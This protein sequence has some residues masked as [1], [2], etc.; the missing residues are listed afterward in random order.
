[1]T[2]YEKFYTMTTHIRVLDSEYDFGFLVRSKMIEMIFDKQLLHANGKFGHRVET[3]SQDLNT[4]HA[5]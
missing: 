4:M 1:M 5:P 2:I 3:R